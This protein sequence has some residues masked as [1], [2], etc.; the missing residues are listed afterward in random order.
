[1]KNHGLWMI[2]G[3][4]VPLLLI[5]ILPLFGIRG[6]GLLFIFLIV[7]FV[8]HLFMMAGHKDHRNGGKPPGKGGGHHGH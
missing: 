5:F 2:I 6:G 1:M 4:I 3:C 7:M 8:A